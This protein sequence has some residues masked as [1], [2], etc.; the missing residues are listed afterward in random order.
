MTRRAVNGL[1]GQKCTP[2]PWCDES[3]ESVLSELRG[4][5]KLPY[6]HLPCARCGAY[7]EADLGA[8]PLCS[9]KWRVSPTAGSPAVRPKL[10]AA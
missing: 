4:Q 1:S 8:C 2:D 10:E 6:L 7:Y 3:P 5:P 9:C